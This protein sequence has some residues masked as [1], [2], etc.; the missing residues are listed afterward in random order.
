MTR[1]E[2]Y[3]GVNVLPP[4][5][6]ALDLYFKKKPKLKKSGTI[7]VTFM[8]EKHRVRLSTKGEHQIVVWFANK[9][10]FARGR[11][12]YDKECEFNTERIS[13]RNREGLKKLDWS[14]LNHRAIFNGLARLLTKLDLDFVTLIRA[15]N[16][17][18]DRRVKIPHTTKWDKTFVNFDDYRKNRWPEDVSPNDRS[19]FIEEVL[20]RVCF[21]FM[22]AAAVGDLKI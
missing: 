13:C 22:S 18:S 16:T 9:E 10:L 7:E 8:A 4:I 21:W 5:A 3:Y 2:E 20:V 19:R 6:W 15:L 12:P 1:E 14:K 17:V 11:C